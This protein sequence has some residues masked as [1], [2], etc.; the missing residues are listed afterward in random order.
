MAIFFLIMDA[1]RFTAQAWGAVTAAPEGYPAFVPKPAPRQLEL[2]QRTWEQLDEAAHHLGILT[3]IGRRLPNPLLLITPYLRRE[4]V[5]SSRIEGTQATMSDLYA[6]ELGQTDLVRA[7]DVE[8]VRNYI[9]AHEHGLES[10][11]PLSLRL[12]RDLHRIL[13][14][15]VRGHERHPGEFR[16]YQNFIGGANGWDATYVGPPVPQMRE[17]LDDL[18]RF[19][20]EDSLRPLVQAAVLHYAFEAIHPFGDGN[21][22]VGRL[23]LPLFLRD[24]KLLPQPLLYLSAYFERN[25]V[26]Y[27]DGLMRVSTHGDWDGWVRFFLNG[28]REQAIEAADLAEALLALQVR[29]RDELQAAHVTANV[30]ALVDNLFINPL[31][32]TSRAQSLLDVSAPTARAAIRAL[33]QHGIV[34]EVTGRNWGKLFQADEIYELLRGD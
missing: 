13:M 2:S 5:L 28:V 32:Y 23:L 34:R 29:Y 16:R 12:I 33:E 30:L 15:E 10:S 27:Y 11:L 17:L 24:R 26:D 19:L 7:P 14:Q 8:E 21:G 1:A 9:T 18:E 31:I 3:G 20:H 4:A 22:R 25:R 6:S